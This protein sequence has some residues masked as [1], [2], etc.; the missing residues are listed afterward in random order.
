[1]GYAVWQF[2][3]AVGAVYAT[4]GGSVQAASREAAYPVRPIRF[5]V[6][7]TP[8]GG[9]DIEGRVLADKLSRRLGQQV[10]VDNRGGGNGNIGM[11]I[12]ARAPADGYTLVIAVV[13]PW[14]INP[15]FYK[16]PFDVLRD[17]APIIHVSSQFGVLAAHPALPAKTIKDLIAL[18]HL[19][20]D[21]LTY[22]SG[23]LGGFSHLS[24]ELFA[25]MANV[26]M[27]HIPYK[28]TGAALTDLS[29]GHIQLLFGGTIPTMP[30]IK[31]GR[32]RPIAT[33]GP[34]RV[35]ALPELP[36][37][38]EA[39]LPGYESLSWTGIGAPAK[40]PGPI[41][42]RLNRELVELL[43]TPDIKE[44]YTAMGGEIAAGTPKQFQDYLKSEFAKFG[45][46]VRDAKIKVDG[47]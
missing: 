32:V 42:D 46:L 26:R 45:T 17:F 24:G 18:A 13:G 23:G 6:P 34:L 44:Q 40:T 5:V 19:K 9:A 1:M 20:P 7:Y 10:V 8:G 14:A 36:T 16:S 43:Q 35:A 31:T 12:V 3:F 4:V 30:H 28:S 21:T 37:I 47:N 39:G 29:G 11:E 22:G 25:L 38:S 33:T 27:T 2:I 15:H 41:I